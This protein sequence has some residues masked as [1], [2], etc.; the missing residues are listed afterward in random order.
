M[1]KK[2]RKPDSKGNVS[3]KGDV[4]E[5]TISSPFGVTHDVHIKP[6]DV[7]E[8]N[9]SSPFGVRKHIDID[10]QELAN[11]DDRKAT[12][13]RRRTSSNKDISEDNMI[14][15]EILLQIM[16]EDILPVLRSEMGDIVEEKIRKV[17]K[18]AEN[19]NFQETS[20]SRLQGEH[21]ESS[22]STQCWRHTRGG[23]PLSKADE[24]ECLANALQGHI[25]EIVDGVVFKDSELPDNL[26]ADGCLTEDECAGVRNK[27][28]R[29][30]QIDQ[31]GLSVS[32]GMRF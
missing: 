25:R 30:D 29:K 4:T 3:R 16:K 20:C 31:R 10:E 7:Q 17:M 21:D 13:P 14:Q 18:E 11:I 32:Y 8:M 9:I 28:D 23:T 1:N 6:S 15:R 27:L 2:D 12:S 5:M 26:L 19:H 24:R 22:V